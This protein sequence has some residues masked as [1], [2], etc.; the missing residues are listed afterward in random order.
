MKDMG[1][2]FPN[3]SDISFFKLGDQGILLSEI[4]EA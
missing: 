3:Y 2:Q 1:K 4:T